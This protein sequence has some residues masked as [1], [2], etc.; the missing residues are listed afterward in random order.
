MSHYWLHLRE[1]RPKAAYESVYNLHVFSF[2]VTL[3]LEYVFE[4][5]SFFPYL[6]FNQR[7]SLL[8]SLS[9]TTLN[10]FYNLAQNYYQFH[11]HNL[12]SEILTY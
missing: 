9:S 5:Q 1:K 2:V 6:L 10:S 12:R 8:T 11:M 7:Y 4:I 3:I